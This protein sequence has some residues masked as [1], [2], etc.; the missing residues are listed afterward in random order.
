MGTDLGG[1][2]ISAAEAAR[3]LGMGRKNF[4]NTY[5]RLGIP[6]VR[7]GRTVRF[8]EKAVLGWIERNESA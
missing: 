2:V 3:L 5:K 1:R 7:R 4:Y 6:A 8:R